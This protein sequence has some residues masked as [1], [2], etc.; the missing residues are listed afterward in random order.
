MY[1]IIG[2]KP[3]IVLFFFWLDIYDIY[4]FHLNAH[5]I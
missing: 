1:K 5:K 2:I 4:V 3:H